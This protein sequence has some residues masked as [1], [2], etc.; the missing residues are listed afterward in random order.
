M[1]SFQLR[2]L[3]TSI[4]ESMPCPKCG[5]NYEAEHIHFLGQVDLT[6]LVQLECT[7]CSLP[8]IINCVISSDAHKIN[9][10]IVSDLNARDVA[11]FRKLAP[12]QTDDLLQMH[13][14]LMSVGGDFTTLFGSKKTR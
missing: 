8:I 12:L 13:R 11:R 6:C 10:R 2:S 14:D 5:A 9:P 4:Q 7:E 3:L 1:N